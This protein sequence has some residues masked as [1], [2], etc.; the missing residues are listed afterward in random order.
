MA[1]MTSQ[2]LVPTHSS[3]FPLS[4]SMPDI[5]SFFELSMER[6]KAGFAT[7]HEAFEWIASSRF[8]VPGQI[9]IPTSRA[10]SR[11]TRSMYQAYFQWNDAR[12]KA[13]AEN[14]DSLS[15]QKQES[16]DRETAMQ[17]VGQG[18]LVFFGKREEYDALVEENEQ[19]LR[20]KAMWNGRKVGEWTGW[21]G[22]LIGRLMNFMRQ[23]VGEQK[24]GQ[25]TEEELEQQ[26]L[27][28]KDIIEAQLVEEQRSR[29]SVQ[30]DVNVEQEGTNVL[31]DSTD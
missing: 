3:T 15:P 9:S 1:Q 23:T 8:Y 20:V 10:K 5:L 13:T 6:W 7:Q 26:V 21:N 28:A 24:I 17:T 18:A 2:A 22:R 25:M 27:R 14:D 16:N 31:K 29:E 4:T 19:R 11:S 12:A 30:A